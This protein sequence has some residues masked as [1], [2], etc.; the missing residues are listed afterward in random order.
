MASLSMENT[1]ARLIHHRTMPVL[2][3]EKEILKYALR[4]F[5]LS[6]S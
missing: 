1:W 5:W 6:L 3:N 4:I 2:S